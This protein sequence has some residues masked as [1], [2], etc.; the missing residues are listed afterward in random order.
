[1]RFF[2]V[3]VFC[4]IGMVGVYAQSDRGTIT[5]TVTDN[6]GAVV[7]HASV[8]AVNTESGTEFPVATSDTGNYTISSLRPGTYTVSADAAGFKKTTRTGIQ[9]AVATNLRVDVT[10]EVGSATESLTV[11]AEAPLLQT[12]DATQTHTLTGSQ[13]GDLPINFGVLSGGYIRSPLTFVNLE[14]GASDTGL[15]SI[16]VNG[17]S[18]YT[19]MYVEG[20]EAG[21]SMNSGSIYETTPNVE[22]IEAVALQSSNFAPEFGQVV[23]GTYNFNVKSGTNSLH[24]TGFEYF[25]NEDFDAGLTFTDDGHGHL[26][27]PTERKNDFGFSVGG[28]IYIPKVYNGKNKSFFFFDWEW[29]KDSRFISGVYQTLPTMDMR[30]GNFSEILTGRTLGTDVTGAPIMENTIYDPASAHSVNGN[31]VT[32]PFA[33]NTIPMSRISPVALK[34]QNLIP[35]PTNGSLVNNW[36]QQYPNPTSIYIPSFK[37]DHNIGEKHHLSFFFSLNHINHLVNTDGLP[38]PITGERPEFERNHTMR[39]NYDYTVRPNLILHMGAGYVMYR[40]PDVAALGVLE[41]DAPGQLGLLGGIPNNFAN[42]SI[43][44]TGFPEITG[45]STNGYGMGLNMGPTNANKYAVDKPTAVVNATWVRGSH[46][47]KM[48]ADWRIDAYRDRNVRGSQGIWNFDN[49]MTG[50]PYLG[51][52]SVNGGQLGNAYADFLLGLSGSASVE[53]PQDPQY[54]KTSW[55]LFVQDAWKVTR[56]LTVTY[57]IRW[58]LQNAWREIHDRIGEFSPTTPNP[59]VGGLLGATIWAGYGAGRCNCEFTS[60]YPYAIGPRLGVAYQIDSKTVFRA[61]WGLTYGTTADS[62]YISNFPIIGGGS[63]GYNEITFV[64]PGFAQPAATFA[65]GLPYTQAQLYPATLDP[66]ITPSPGQLN[67]PPYWMDPQGGRPPR[68]NQWNIGLQHQFTPNFMA[69]AAYVG[70]RGVWLEAN[71]LEDVNGL[72]TQKLS[73]V[74]LSLNNPANLT[75]LSSTFASGAPQ[76]AGFKVPYS[77]FPLGASLAQALRPF[78]Q[79]TS[80]STAWSPLGSSWYDALQAKATMRE[81]HGFYGQ[82]AFTWQQEL[83]NSEGCFGLWCFG[84]INDVYNRG[85]QK[86]ISGSSIPLVAAFMFNYR[87]PALAQNKLL[88]TLQ[89]DWTIGGSFRYQS[90]LPIATPGATNNL[91]A[92][93]P[94]ATPG[95]LANRVPGVPLFTKDPNCHCYDPS[96]TFILNPAAWSQPAPGQWGTAAAYYNDYRWQRQPAESMSLGRI[97]RLR[98]GMTLS[99]RAEFFNIFNRVFLNA[100]TSGNAAQTQVFNGQQAVSGFGWINTLTTPIQAAGGA[101]PTVRNGQLVARFQ[102]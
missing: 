74:G 83:T 82:F 13:V 19:T 99:I 41:Y 81:W 90:G 89:R 59:S 37:L 51:S 77:S 87:V 3:V 29:Y 63:I 97:F 84:A 91:G 80:I 86:T 70:N 55:S 31:S 8:V 25:V 11:T 24:G 73:S 58:D 14:P 95:T 10:L 53:T 93:L 9:V 72:T 26:I 57:G 44:A 40:S 1:M 48:G 38:I 102:F 35:L 101:V 30:N 65:Q 28:P 33:G 71:N 20:Q 2:R 92:V 56:K 79:Y 94:R 76:A 54:R 64:S 42:P 66:G 67:P 16:R 68:I 23:G 15:N 4:L 34:I 75:L 39:F 78:P 88:R 50:L 69:E 22:A 46:S 62:H 43:T 18:G 12:E 6:S 47:Y 27:R 36:E 32:T 96:D 100:P 60:A 5:G 52:T 61:G 21:N 49:S 98:E 85:L 7:P 17:F 45:L